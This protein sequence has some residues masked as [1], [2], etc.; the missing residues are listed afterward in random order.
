MMPRGVV[1]FALRRRR[2]RRRGTIHHLFHAVRRRSFFISNQVIAWS[3]LAHDKSVFGGEE[4]T[5]EVPPP[6]NFGDTP[7][8]P[9]P[10]L[11]QAVSTV[12]VVDD[13]ASGRR[14]RA[15]GHVVRESTRK[16]VRKNAL[17][18][19][20]CE[21]EPSAPTRDRWMRGVVSSVR[22]KKPLDGFSGEPRGSTDGVSS[23]VD[24]ADAPSGSTSPRRA[25][26]HPAGGSRKKGARSSK[27]GRR[28]ARGSRW[29]RFVVSLL[30]PTPPPPPAGDVAIITTVVGWP[31]VTQCR[32]CVLSLG[33]WFGRREQDAGGHVLFECDEHDPVGKLSP[34][35]ARAQA[36]YSKEHAEYMISLKLSAEAAAAAAEAAKEAVRCCR[37]SFLLAPG[38]AVGVAL[39]RRGSSAS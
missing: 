9:S 10:D 3:L 38:L 8:P 17:G 26:P 25:S 30:I 18:T 7:S 5:L 22:T 16:A 23:S 20:S 27:V 37:F 6:G 15:A 33:L 31:G 24:A 12:A 13:R 11:F 34:E 28:A 35:A 36:L 14:W 4:L 39:R 21:D 32:A 29:L 1:V 2:R 19:W